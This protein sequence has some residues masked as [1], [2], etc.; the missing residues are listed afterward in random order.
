MNNKTKALLALVAVAVGVLAIFH[1]ASANPLQV[2]APCSTSSSATSTVIQLLAL[3]NS[4]TTLQCDLY[5]G[6]S[7]RLANFATLLI[8]QTASSTG[9]ILLT[10][11][12]YSQDGIDWYGDTLGLST[13]TAA[14]SITTNMSYVWNAAATTRDGKAILLK[15]PVRYVRAN[16]RQ[17]AATSSIWAQF[18]PGREIAE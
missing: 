14:T 13:T 7:P 8:Q 9:S 4:T 17:T 3:S 6:G 10:S 15:T 16:F 11:I 5:S 2:S 12:E 1:T 18:V